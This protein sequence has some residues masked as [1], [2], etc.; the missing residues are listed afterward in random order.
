M[1]PN[2]IMGI[3]IDAPVAA[4]FIGLW[5]LSDPKHPERLSNLRKTLGIIN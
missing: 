5:L 3:C 4:F 2:L 1:D